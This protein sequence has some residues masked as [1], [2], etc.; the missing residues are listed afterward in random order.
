MSKKLLLADDSITIQKVIGITFANEDVTLAIADNGDTALDLARAEPPDLVLADVLMPGLNGYELCEA[1]KSDPKLAGTPVLLLTGTF[2]PFEEDKARAAGADDW[3][4]KPFESQALI[5]RVQKLLRLS[6]DQLARPASGAAGAA[7]PQADMWREKP[8]EETAPD[9][10]FNHDVEDAEESL[11]ADFTLDEEDMSGDGVPS[12]PAPAASSP[13]D[14]RS[15]A[16][17]DEDTE[18]ILD[19]DEA[20]ILDLDE[21][22]ILENEDQ[23]IV[24]EAAEEPQVASPAPVVEETDRGSQMPEELF[25]TDFSTPAEDEFVTEGVD[26]EQDWAPGAAETVFAEEAVASAP[27]AF[28]L[29]T[30]TEEAITPAAAGA[31]LSDAA[32]EAVVERV[33]AEVVNRLA[34][35]ILEKIA[36]EVVPDLAESLIKD[37]IRKIKEALK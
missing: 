11:W 7:A 34:G 20:D 2:E 28:E 8:A 9:Q 32:V 22:D 18:D 13:V 6:P 1:V 33:A 31:A 10:P 27:A 19:L 14:L 25:S 4:A 24:F 23:E 29:S 12:A 30:D 36:W 37:E 15:A 35:T 5:D 16:D 17:E 26:E 21:S 3:I